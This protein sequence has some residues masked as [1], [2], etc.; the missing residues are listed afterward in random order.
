MSH[1]F[2]SLGLPLLMAMLVHDAYAADTK[3]YTFIA[4]HDEIVA[5][6]KK[7]G[8]LRVVS[9][10]DPSNIKASTAGFK[11][12]YPFIDINVVESQGV[13]A[14]QRLLLSIK[15]GT[16]KEWDIILVSA[17]FRD[18]YPRYLWK[19]DLLGMAKQGVVKIPPP[20]IDGETKNILG[21]HTLFQVTA[22]NK[23]LVPSDLAPKSYEDFLRPEFKGKKFAVDIRPK[24]V[25]GL[26]PVWGLE[27]TLAFARKVAAQEPIWVRG[28]SSTLPRILAGEILMMMGPNYGS[29]RQAQLKDATGV[30]QYSIPEP[31]PVRFGNSLAILASAAHPHAAILWLEWLANP[32]AQKI[33]DDTEPFASS[34]YVHGGAIED[35]EALRHVQEWRK[36]VVEAFGFPKA[37]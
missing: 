27:K 30:L 33:A 15:S 10:M 11:K 23:N 3:D 25:T 19:I 37:K 2:K 24:D 31:V 28:S 1:F 29:V 8:K 34:M 20:M 16:A 18:E 32:A 21:T 36:K 22:Y 13:V 12:I 6:A 17:D 5:K 35:T 14:A 7:E 4:S 26:V 9:T